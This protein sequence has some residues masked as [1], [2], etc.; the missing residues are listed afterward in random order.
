M[1]LIGGILFI[2]VI[3]SFTL[4]HIV[5][6]LRFSRKWQLLFP[7]HWSFKTSPRSKYT[8]VCE[9]SLTKNLVEKDSSLLLVFSRDQRSHPVLS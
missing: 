6:T 3:L 9:V 4:R 7:V 1:L 5:F 2:I 8:E